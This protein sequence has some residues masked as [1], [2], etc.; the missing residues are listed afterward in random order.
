MGDPY[1]NE[2]LHRGSLIYQFGDVANG[3][4]LVSLICSDVFA[5]T[6]ADAVA[7]YHRSL[8]LHIQLNPQPRQHQYRQ[9]REKLFNYSGDET[10]LICLN[11]AGDVCE[12]SSGKQKAW[13][14][15][16]GSAWYLRPKGFDT[17]DLTLCVNH[18]RG[19]YYTWLNSSRAH[20]LFLNYSAGAYLIEATKVAHAGVPASVSRRVGPKLQQVFV[21]D[22]GTAAALTAQAS[23]ADGF[24]GIL[25]QSG[26][27]QGEIQR[28]YNTNPI[29]A[30]RVLAIC[31]G[32]IVPGEWYKVGIL[33]SFG[34][35][36]TEI[37]RRITFCQDVDPDADQFRSARL[38]RCANL[39]QILSEKSNLP[40]A[41]ADLTDGFGFV[42]QDTYP[43]QNVISKANKRATTIYLGE[44]ADDR[45]V[46]QVA[47]FMAENL[48]RD[49]ASANESN[50]A[51]QR[52][53]VWY[54]RDGQ[55]RLHN[56]DRYSRYDDP[57]STSDLDLTRQG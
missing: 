30:E 10:E 20:V 49:A 5:F 29:V 21:W 2:H 24:S 23:A 35:G 42:W 51:R 36:T 22:P 19:L 3:L 7:L 18:K 37:V 14:N 27:A 8:V 56:P 54:R 1:E 47:T 17:Q 39:W 53:A 52:L 43:H 41:L 40:P 9:Y 4:Q 33:D 28:L 44:D 38:L 48:R 57:R 16:S 31:A 34:I 11:W 26:N 32:K 13:K 12:W 15:P 46:E 25:A 6:D 45:L 55:L 50:T